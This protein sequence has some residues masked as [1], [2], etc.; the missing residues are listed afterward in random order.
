[1]RVAG[2]LA[3]LTAGQHGCGVADISPCGEYAQLCSANGELDVALVARWMCER[4]WRIAGRG[5]GYASLEVR[6]L[7][8]YASW[9]GR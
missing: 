3:G 1:M 4:E 8:M 7:E 6:I 5:A 9:S 2:A